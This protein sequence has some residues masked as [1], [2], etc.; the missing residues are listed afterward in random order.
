MAEQ[1]KRITVKVSEELH[2][3]VKIKAAMVG[4]SVSDILREYL[5]SWVEEPLSEPDKED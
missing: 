2:R 3:R 1:E 4:K 5:E